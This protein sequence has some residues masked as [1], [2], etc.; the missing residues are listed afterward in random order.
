MAV[1]PGHR[2]GDI[3]CTPG[4][5]VQGRVIATPAGWAGHLWVVAFNDFGQRAEAPVAADGSFTLND[6]PPGKY[7]L[8]AGHD[9]YKNP[10]IARIPN[11]TPLARV[12]PGHPWKGANVVTV[13]SGGMVRGVEVP[14]L[15]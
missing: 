14:G 6:L 7:G 8:K 5:G 12:V 11:I 15:P 4:G 13:E 2:C 9:S 1:L 3:A 10:D